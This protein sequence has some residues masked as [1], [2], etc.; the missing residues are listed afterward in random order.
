MFQNNDIRMAQAIRKPCSLLR[1]F[2]VNHSLLVVLFMLVVGTGCSRGGDSEQ[3]AS[4]TPAKP[5]MELDDDLMRE[6]I[7]ATVSVPADTADHSAEAKT[8]AMI[9][10]FY[11]GRDFKS[12][13]LTSDS[14]ASNASRVLAILHTS[15]SHGLPGSLYHIKEIENLYANVVH[16]AQSGDEPD[17]RLAA[18]LEILLSTSFV[19]FTNHLRF[20][21][22]DPHQLEGDAGCGYPVHKLRDQERLEPLMSSDPFGYFEAHSPML[23][24]YQRL[25]AGLAFLESIERSGGWQQLPV[26]DAKIK[27][28]PGTR[29]LIMT[30][31]AGRMLVTCKARFTRYLLETKPTFVSSTD[32]LPAA[33]TSFAWSTL[34]TGVYDPSIVPLVKETQ[35]LYGMNADGVITKSLIDK[36]NIPVQERVLQVKVN[37][38]RMRWLQMPDGKYV[39]VNIPDFRLSTVDGE[40]ICNSIKI[41]CGETKNPTPLL[42]DE[43]KYVVLNPPWN[44]PI[45]ISRKEKMPIARKDPEKLRRQGYK[46]L[47]NGVSKDPTTI[48][49]SKY[50][51]GKSATFVQAPSEGNALGKIK[52][53][54]PNDFSVYLHDTPVRSPFRNA[55]RAVSHGCMRVQEPMKLFQFVMPANSEW[56]VDKVQEYLHSTRATKWITLTKQIPVFI[57]YHSSWVTDTGELHLRGDIYGKDKLAKKVFTVYTRVQ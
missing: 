3:N 42:S 45:A 23:G 36:L 55:V 44:V 10:R 7:N 28:T 16:V 34:N 46:V 29:H 11:S 38:D 9:K 19:N 22:L 20:G 50:P 57:V 18:Q 21:I 30:V 5:G 26:I 15:D 37:L 14:G 31:I 43:I 24:D 2:V 49:W 39:I 17:Y 33:D 27:I 48:D 1:D 52:F 47:E 6:A 35:R 56:T 8:R 51:P 53:L 40:R 41:C 32:T 12:L 13:W 25:R 4:E 54:F